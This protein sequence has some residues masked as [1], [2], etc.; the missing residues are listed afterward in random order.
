[1][2]PMVIGVSFLYAY[3][4]GFDMTSHSKVHEKRWVI[5]G[6]MSLSLII[7]MLNNVTLNVALP[8][9]SKDLG[10]DNTELQWIVDSY[11]LIFGGTLL[12]MGALGD[13]FGRK[14][15]LQAG[16]ILVGIASI[17]AGLYS[18]STREI[19]FARAMMGFGAALVMPATLSIVIVVFPPEERGKAIGIWTMMAGIGA[20]I[21]LLVGGWAV[22]NYN[23]QMVFLINIP[24]ITLALISGFI[25]VP[26]SKDIQN[27]PLDPYGAILSILALGSILYAII[28]API[29]GWTSL[30]FFIV[31]I[32]G[33]ILTYSFI[34]WERRID[35]PMLPI[36]FFKSTGFS[37][38][39]VAISLASFVMFS[40]MFTQMLHF[41]L[42]RDHSAFE[43]AVRF[44]FL[45]LGLMPAAASSDALSKKYGSNNIVSFGLF[46]ISVAMGIFTTVE[47]DTEYFRLAFIFFLL[48]FG[49]GLT[50]APSTTIVMDSIPEDKAGVGSATNDA[51]REIGG[52]LGIAIGGSILNEVY[53][54]NMK[55][56]EEL[57]VSLGNL[58]MESFP[59]AIRIG[60]D[61]LN[62]G[63]IL[64]LELIQNA[65]LAFMEGMIVSAKVMGIIALIGAILVK[66]YMPTSIINDEID[67]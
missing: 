22:E 11:A 51:S 36:N 35:F 50:L 43:A 61:L 23:W 4:F 18:D 21:G 30:K 10:A 66:L 8:E 31:V 13:R 45:P 6:I 62:D 63:N 56:P 33:I 60:S 55:I 3:F 40:F 44:L 12:V 17:N 64:G 42:I 49:I 58:P 20:P 34:R 53:Q 1:M 59:S 39:L 14:K 29:I 24:F 47:T 48:G 9:L 41:Q 65:K 25:L 37:L 2:K 46:L 5:L 32:L 27:R 16:L 15:A 57:S 7:V 19:I 52:A 26:D 54:R 28:E 67:S 38:G